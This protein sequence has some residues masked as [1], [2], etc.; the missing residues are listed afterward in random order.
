M[1][2][3]ETMSAPA[4]FTFNT[5]AVEQ[6]RYSADIFAPTQAAENLSGLE[7]FMATPA[8]VFAPTFNIF[9]LILMGIFAVFLLINSYRDIKTGV[10]KPWWKP[11]VVPAAC[12]VAAVIISA[13]TGTAEGIGSIIATLMTI[14]FYLM[15]YFKRMGGA[16]FICMSLCAIMVGVCLGWIPLLIWVFIGLIFI[17]AITHLVFKIVYGNRLIEKTGCTMSQAS[18]ELEPKCKSQ[19]IIP[20]PAGGFIAAVLIW[21]L[22]WGL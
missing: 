7:A 21:V 2:F 6:M 4:D 14:V 5:P 9:V 19:R 22:I 8:D 16:D 17:P 15:A 1:T 20:A 13:V 18:K 12:T 10:L 11:W 3:E